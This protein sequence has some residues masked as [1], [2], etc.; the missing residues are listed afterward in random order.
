[1]ELKQQTIQ[2]AIILH[3]KRDIYKFNKSVSKRCNLT[4]TDKLVIL[5][6]TDKKI[7]LGCL[8]PDAV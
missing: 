3:D 1:M 7:T 5:D 2:P 6:D 4:L 8:I